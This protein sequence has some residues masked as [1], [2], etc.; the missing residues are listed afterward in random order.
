MSA[1]EGDAAL[2]PPSAPVRCWFCG[3]PEVIEL[4]EM[5]GHQFMWKTC[6]EALHES[7]CHHTR[8]DESGVS[9]VA[10][11]WEQ[12]T[13]VRGRGWHSA[14][15]ARSNTN[16]YIDKVRWSRTFKQRAPPP[17]VRK[18]RGADAVCGLTLTPVVRD[19]GLGL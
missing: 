19:F 1:G 14:S 15:R 13:V 9:L 18:Q 12:E 6:C 11:G 2:L 4:A 16:A 17:I 10:A 7:L 3:E 8:A 5:W